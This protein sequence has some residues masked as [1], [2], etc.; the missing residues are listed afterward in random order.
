M[1]KEI[2][3]VTIGGCIGFVSSFGTLMASSWLEKRGKLKVYSRFVYS[4]LRN[5]ESW[6]F[7]H[8]DSNTI[9]FD[10]PLWVEIQNT[11]KETKVIRDFCIILYYKGKRIAKMIQINKFV[12]EGKEVYYGNNGGYSFIADPRSIKRYECQFSIKKES[13]EGDSDF[14]EIKLRYF[15]ECD[16]EKI[17][18]LKFVK[19]C[20]NICSFKIDD[21]WNLLC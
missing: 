10:I 2:I 16:N 3:L 20:W 6:G 19:D 15:D 8:S 13:F 11:S 17:F 14:D 9:Y 4:K 12:E 5:N 18:H 21:D 7:H 1:L